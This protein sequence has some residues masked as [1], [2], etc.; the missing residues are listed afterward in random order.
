VGVDDVLELVPDVRRRAGEVEACRALPRDL[1]EQLADR[2]AFVLL[3]P[4]E[5]GGAGVSLPSLYEVTRAIAEADGSVGWVVGQGAAWAGAMTVRIDQKLVS[6]ACSEPRVNFAGSATPQ[7]TV[8]ITRDGDDFVVSG[9][10]KWG[11]GCRHATWF[12]PLSFVSADGGPPSPTFFFVP[13]GEV[14]LHDNWDTLGMRGTG[15]GDYSLHDAR[16]PSYRTFV[17]GRPPARPDLPLG[18]LVDGNWHIALPATATLVGVAR[19]AVAE[20][21]AL[22][23]ADKHLIFN[24]D[25]HRANASVQRSFAQSVAALDAVDLHAWTALHEMWAIAVEGRKPTPLER[26]TAR[27]ALSNAARVAAAVVDEMGDLATADSIW[28]GSALERCLRDARTHRMHMSVY[29][30]TFEKIGRIRLGLIDD[31]PLI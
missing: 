24:A 23:L 1:F 6:E 12:A 29:A 16:V 11:T 7:G 31:D 2:G 15:S 30:A 18:R 17:M 21:E 4:A 8:T 10:W 28:R 13:A 22:L 26:A 19:R 3:M 20:V 27:G 5:F 9:R 25:P 14:E